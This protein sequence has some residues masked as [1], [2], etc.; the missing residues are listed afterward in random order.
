MSWQGMIN[1]WLPAPVHQ[2]EPLAREEL[3]GCTVQ[4]VGQAVL[5]AHNMTLRGSLRNVMS[6]R[7][8]TFAEFQSLTSCGENW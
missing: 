5:S 3:T 2:H 8:G 4:Y 6:A 7:I 1:G